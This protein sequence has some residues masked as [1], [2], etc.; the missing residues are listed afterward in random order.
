[1]LGTKEY[2]E[3]WKANSIFFDDVQ[4]SIDNNIRAW[5]E[6]YK[7]KELAQEDQ[8]VPRMPSTTLTLKE[9]ALIESIIDFKVEDLW[10]KAYD[11]PKDS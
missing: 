5:L 10:R 3:L 9:I 2:Q 8:I 1:M 4:S 6:T 7:D 11:E